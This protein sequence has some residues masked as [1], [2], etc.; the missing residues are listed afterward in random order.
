[1]FRTLI[2]AAGIGLLAT[3]YTPPALAFDSSQSGPADHFTA[4]DAARFSKDI[5]TTLAQKGARVAMVFRAGAPR[6]DLPEGFNYTHG[7]FWVY[8]PVNLPDGRQVM[9]YS[10]YN[11]YHG[12]GEDLPKDRSELVT[13]FPFDFVSGSRADD[14][15]IIIP[16]PEVQKR[17]YDVIG[18]P[19]YEALHVPGYS[20][21]ANPADARYQ[22]C[23]EFMLDVLSSAVWQTDNYEQIKVNLG[24]YFKA[25]PVKEARGLKRFLAPIADNRLKTDDHSGKVK[26]ATYESIA[27]FME[28]YGYSSEVFTLTHNAS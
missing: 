21:I 24:A 8:Q 23:T 27:A 5:E 20:L 12:N 22:N 26:T 3:V 1:M 28:T 19:T 18:S 10:V 14:V 4:E 11:L 13:D 9:G 16:S 17:L 2:T 6:A 15:G 25:S 7:A